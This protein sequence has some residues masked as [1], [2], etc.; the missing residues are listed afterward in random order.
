MAIALIRTDKKSNLAEAREL[1][2]WC[3]NIFVA[4][5]DK[6]IINSI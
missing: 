4:T 1:L 6:N 2:D 5:T 3:I